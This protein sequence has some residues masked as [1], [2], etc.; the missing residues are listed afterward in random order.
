MKKIKHTILFTFLLSFAAIA[1]Q[2][3]V[4]AGGI[5]T[6]IGG[7]ETFSVG[8][9]VYT[10]HD[11]ETKYIAEGV[12]Q[13]YEISVFNSIKEAETITLTCSAFPNPTSNILILKIADYSITNLYARLFDSNGKLFE[14]IRIT[15]RETKINMNKFGSGVYHLMLIADYQ[16]LKTFKIIKN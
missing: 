10:T 13:P 16:L 7:S 1:Q 3:N 8:Q 2:G 14:S 5:A 11:G 9:V 12:Q 6:G 4:A 15:E